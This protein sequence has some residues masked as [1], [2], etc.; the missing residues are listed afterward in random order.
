MS[1]STNQECLDAIG[2]D[3]LASCQGGS[4]QWN[5]LKSSRAEA[6][7]QMDSY[8]AVQACTPVYTLEDPGM[9]MRLRDAEIAIVRWLE[10]HRPDNVSIP[11]RV[12]KRYE[13]VIAWLEKVARFEVLLRSTSGEPGNSVQM[14]KGA[15]PGY[16]L[17]S[18]E[19]NY[20]TTAGNVT[21]LMELGDTGDDGGHITP[22]V[23]RI[24]LFAFRGYDAMNPGSCVLTPTI[25][26]TPVT[27]PG[28]PLTWDASR[29]RGRWSVNTGAGFAFVEND[30]LGVQVAQDN[31]VVAGKLL[32]AW[33]LIEVD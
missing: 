32:K 18:L 24:V 30:L 4:I 6:A 19:F 1:Y 33:M 10:W 2:G 14:S 7:G 23:G 5:L 28:T 27:W 13:A 26:G 9:A 22:Y 11:E 29:R 20:E 25:N 21:G 12:Q 17:H 8:L 15:I 16:R 3:E 31:G